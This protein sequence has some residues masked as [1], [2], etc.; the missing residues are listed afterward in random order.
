MRLLDLVLICPY[1]VKTGDKILLLFQSD[2][3]IGAPQAANHDPGS[4]RFPRDYPGRPGDPA[5]DD[6]EVVSKNDEEEGMWL[7]ILLGRQRHSHSGNCLGRPT[8]AQ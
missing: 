4:M 5:L 2:R 6:Q 7:S 8:K 3:A 1:P